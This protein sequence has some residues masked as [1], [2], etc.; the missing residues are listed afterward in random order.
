MYWIISLFGILLLIAP[1]VLGFTDNTAALWTCYG[2]GLVV[3]LFAS[4]K[5][6]TGDEGKW[7]GVVSGI[8]GVLAVIAPFV[9]GF[10][11]NAAALWTCV[12]LGLG[13]ALAAGY[14][15]LAKDQAK[16]EVLMAGLG[17]ILAVLTPFIMGLV[18]AFLAC[19]HYFATFQ[20]P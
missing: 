19:W 13:V 10:S 2:L 15:A 7:E 14:E 5:A 12:I 17:G 16:R 9:L 18:L 4:T 11:D 20:T 6:V 1:F 8:A 3:A